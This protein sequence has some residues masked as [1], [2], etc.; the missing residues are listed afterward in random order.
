[1]EGF[2]R[3]LLSN[4][5]LK[6]FFFVPDGCVYTEKELVDKFGNTRR[7]DRLII[8]KDEAW[9][10]DYKSFLLRVEAGKNSSGIY[11]TGQPDI[12]GIEGE[13]YLF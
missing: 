5:G 7:I 1:M 2:L 9:V 6:N 11:G 13:G 8:K 3:S 10:V 12:S 4:A